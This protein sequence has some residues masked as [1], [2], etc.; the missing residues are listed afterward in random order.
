M[1]GCGFGFDLICWLR[2]RVCGGFLLVVCL[3]GAFSFMFWM[4]WFDFVDFFRVGFGVLFWFIRLLFG[5]V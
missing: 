5:C 4:V 3:F 1:A 2:L